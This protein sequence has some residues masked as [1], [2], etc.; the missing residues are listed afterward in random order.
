[1]CAVR[2]RRQSDRIGGSVSP[3]AALGATTGAGPISLGPELLA[4]ARLVLDL[5]D[6]DRDSRSIH[7][8]PLNAIASWLLSLLNATRAPP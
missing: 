3:G 1:M 6:L 4:P 5:S 8:T 2:Q 7:L